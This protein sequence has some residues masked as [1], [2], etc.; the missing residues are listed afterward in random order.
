[1][2]EVLLSELAEQ[3]PRL[4][5]RSGWRSVDER[6]YRAANCGVR[7]TAAVTPAS[8]SGKGLWF[9]KLGLR[10]D[11]LVGPTTPLRQ[12]ELP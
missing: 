12:V 8:T 6:P 2:R 5:A 9:R 7:W 4:F 1:M 11:E 3:L 10:A